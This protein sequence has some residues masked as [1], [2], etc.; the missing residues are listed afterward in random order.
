MD[1]KNKL[2]NPSEITKYNKDT[3]KA[4]G[5]KHPAHGLFDIPDGSTMPVLHGAICLTPEDFLKVKTLLE[6]ECQNNKEK[7]QK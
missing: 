2:V 3:C 1:L 5:I 6:T 4:E 7:N